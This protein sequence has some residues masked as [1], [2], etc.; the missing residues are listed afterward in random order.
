MKEGSNPEFLRQKYQFEKTDEADRAVKKK[1]RRGE[2]VRNIPSERI[3]AYLERLDIVMNPPKLEGHES[4]DRKARNISMMKRFMHETLIVKPDVATDEYLV[5][6]QKQERAMGYGDVDISA[7]IRDQITHAVEAIA[8]GSDIHQELQGLENEKK[9]MAE[10]IVAKIEDQ[11]RSLDKWIDYLATDDAATA[12]PDWFRY[13]AMRS[14]TGLSSF[15]K[16]TKAF[17]SRD[18]ETMNPFPELDQAV[19][20]K[21]RD[22]VEHDRA[23]KERLAASLEELERAERRHNQKRQDAVARYLQENHVDLPKG[24]ENK[25]RRAD[26]MGKISEAINIAPFD[27]STFEIETPVDD[28]NLEPEVQS[29]LDT[30]DFARLYALEFAKLIPTSETLLHNIVGQ[31]VKYKQGSEPAKL[32][33]SIERHKTGW[34]TAG[35]EVARSQLSRGDF[36][37]YYSQ[38]ESGTNSI[39]RAAIRMEDDKIAEVRGIAPDQNLD[40][41]IAPVVG[42]KMKEFPDGTAYE[43]KAAD[44]RL[45]TLIEQKTVA[46]NPL[47]KQELFFLYEINVSIE[48]FGYDK[49]PRVVEL[50]KERNTEEDMFVVFECDESQIAHSVDQINEST[51]AYVGKLEPGI[52]DRLPKDVEHVYTKFPDGCIRRQSIEI[53]GKDERELK[54]LLEGNW[55]EIYSYTKSMMEHEDFKRSLREADPKQPDWKKWKLKSLEEAK[56]VRLRVEDLGFSSGATT[57]QIYARAEELGLELCPPEVGPQ[58]RLQYVNQPMNEYVYVG[59]KQISDSDGSRR[60]F[61]VGRG[62]G[63]SWLNGNWA[64]PTDR[65]AANNQFVFRLRK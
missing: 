10:E 64:L 22:H 11:K 37:V 54:E 53:G 52:F 59:M 5:H 35:E 32:V 23:Y 65:W 48:G 17:P 8:K 29:A 31:W 49:D 56:L 62:D 4:F 30:K 58:F 26:I 19:L 63:G 61:S 42:E 46:G 38:D 44:M 33:Q 3:Q 7:D 1:E 13:W 21:V 55:Y 45:L 20:G 47:T 34:C 51:K 24:K 18:E 2:R 15:D 43:K 41:H 50:R 27:P 60:V 25:D 57:D 40:P 16:D 36:Y 9:Q 39:P 12:Y 28:R 14:V 6:Q